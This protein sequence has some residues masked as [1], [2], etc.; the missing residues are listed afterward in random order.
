MM[1]RIILFLALVAILCTAL[2]WMFRFELAYLNYRIAILDAAGRYRVPPRLVA[3]VIW[4]ESRFRPNCRGQAGEL[5]L[6]QV[7]P[8]SGREWA[9][10]EGITDFSAVALLNPATNVLAGTWYLGRAIDRWSHNH[11]PIPAALAEYNAGHSSAARWAG[12]SSGAHQAFVDSISYIPTR[13]YVQHIVRRFRA[14]GRPWELW[15]AD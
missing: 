1:R 14:F 2:A 9:K 6:M 10:T 12:A 3:A 8:N 15:L 13:R 5:G 11:D 7:M 4:Q